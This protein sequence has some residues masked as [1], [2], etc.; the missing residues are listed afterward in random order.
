[1]S[2][3]SFCQWLSQTPWS[4]YLRE[5]PY[6]FPV[7]IIIH[8]IA[9]ALFGGMVV[10]GNLRVLGWA[11][12]SVPVSQVIGQFRP[13]KWTGFAILLISGTLLAMSDPLEYYDNIMFWISMLLLVAAGL[14]AMIFHFGAY[15]SVAAW[16]ESATAP[17]GARRW[18]GV[19][20]FLWIALV[21]AGR[22][23][24]FF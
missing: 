19:S 3:L 23:T 24:A 9:I 1:M 2:F 10:M 11:M 12:R 13:W 14:N 17:P 8:I 7:L 20:L 16:D 5:A 4:V 18:A 15:R 22:A 6:P 21:F